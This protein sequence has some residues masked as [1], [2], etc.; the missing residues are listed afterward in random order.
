VNDLALYNEI[1]DFAADWLENLIRAGEIAPG[2]VD[3]RSILDLTPD[4]ILPYRQVHFF[5]GIGGWSKA[6]RLVGWP[7]DQPGWSASLPCPPWSRGRIWHKETAG[8]KDHRDLWPAFFRLVKACRP[9]RITGEQV[10]GKKAQPW[11]DRTSR[12]LKKV[13]YNIHSDTRKANRYWSPQGRERFYFS[14]DLGS[15]RRQGLV[16]SGSIGA[17][18]PWRWRGE[19]DLR[20]IAKAPF[21][22]GDCWPQPLIRRGDDGLRTRVAS[23]RAYGNAIDPYVAAQF[24]AEVMEG[25]M[26]AKYP[27]NKPSPSST[28]RSGVGE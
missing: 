14:A 16:E 10:A 7:D 6:W 9:A 17:A 24:I 13:G 8:K 15:T 3:R 25:R 28:P 27:S 20:A 12:D 11:I 2:R 19:A 23:L 5:A 22:Q 4:D 21:K 26:T 1:D 18:R